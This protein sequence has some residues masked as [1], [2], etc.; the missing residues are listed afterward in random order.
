MEATQ[1]EQL[2]DLV[3]E[4][5]AEDYENSSRGWDY[6]DKKE[7]MRDPY[8]KFLLPFEKKVGGE[9][10][11]DDERDEGAVPGCFGQ[12]LAGFCS[13]MICREKR[14]PVIYV[15]E[16]HLFDRE[17]C[18]GNGV[19]KKLMQLVE[20]IGKKVGV[21]KSMLTV[22]TTNMRAERF[23]RSLGYTED[24]IS[25]V[26]KVL[27]SGKVRKPEYFILSKGL[28]LHN[29]EENGAEE[30]KDENVKTNQA[31]HEIVQVGGRKR[32]EDEDVVLPIYDATGF[33]KNSVDERAP[34][35]QCFSRLE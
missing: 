31:T 26:A 23:Y 28:L 5:S 25:P 18:K 11:D 24:Q 13:F 2:C 20:S 9:E 12:S 3:E 17:G 22:F 29:R 4:T 1:L 27:K 7:E 10:G 21:V 32:K 6:F 33:L 34:K 15:Y 19:G 35:T 8:M 14:L 30:G 16:I